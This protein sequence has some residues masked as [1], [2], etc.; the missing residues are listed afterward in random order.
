MKLYEVT[1][2]VTYQGR[3]RVEAENI[4]EAEVK[5]NA[6]FASGQGAPDKE[7][8]HVTDMLSEPVDEN[9]APNVCI[10]CEG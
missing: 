2:T 10:A 6:Y 7:I 5:A 1:A 8:M 4:T 9:P 3:V